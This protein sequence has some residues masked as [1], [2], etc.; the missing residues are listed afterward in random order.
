LPGNE[1]KILLHGLESERHP[2][3][4]IYKSGPVE[5]VDVWATWIPDIVI[6]VVS[7]SSR[8]RDYEEKP[9]EYLDFGI[10]EYWIINAEKQ[11][12]LVLRRF[13]GRW[14]KKLVR[15]PERYKTR[16]LPGFEFDCG[17]VFKAAGH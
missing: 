2:D 15:P 9:D 12:M 4:A 3:L 13:G 7:R 6:E 8:R 16:L 5:A 1:C 10:R 14:V 17:A 11:E